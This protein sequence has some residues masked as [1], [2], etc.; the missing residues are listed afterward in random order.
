MSMVW[1]APSIMGFQATNEVARH[2]HNTVHYSKVEVLGRETDIHYNKVEVLDRETDRTSY[3]WKGRSSIH[4]LNVA[5][6][7]ESEW[8]VCFF[9]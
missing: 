4:R 7:R 8:D 9:S 3:P 1:K 5:H 2:Y 6:D